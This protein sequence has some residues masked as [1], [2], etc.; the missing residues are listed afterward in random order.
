MA[1]DPV[2]AEGLKQFHEYEK[3]HDISWSIIATGR[4]NDIIIYADHSTY[5]IW[6][7]GNPDQAYCFHAKIWAENFLKKLK[8]NNPRV[9]K[10]S[11]LY[12]IYKSR[13]AGSKSKKKKHG[14]HVKP[15]INE[16]IHDRYKLK[17]KPVRDPHRGVMF[18]ILKNDGREKILKKKGYHGYTWIGRSSSV[19]P[20]KASVERERNKGDKDAWKRYAKLS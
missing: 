9:V 13:L 6:W 12:S 7:T 1:I 17:K 14:R 18:E 10:T 15:I 16:S 2:V 20:E 4:N 3:D 5:G 19:C 8:F 11:D